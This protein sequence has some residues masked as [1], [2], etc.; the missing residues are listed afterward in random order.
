ML[1]HVDLFR[2]EFLR[3][4]VSPRHTFGIEMNV[5][6]AFIGKSD[7]SSDCYSPV[8]RLQV[9]RLLLVDHIRTASAQLRSLLVQLTLHGQLPMKPLLSRHNNRKLRQEE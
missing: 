9:V 5:Y 6:L 3:F 4:Y 1:Y 8:C 2:K 7:C